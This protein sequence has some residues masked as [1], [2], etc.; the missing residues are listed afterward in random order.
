MTWM[1][2]VLNN[3]ATNVVNSVWNLASWSFWQ[4]LVFLIAIGLLFTVVSY[5]RKR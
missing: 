2:D 4:I 1:T 5:F 3:I